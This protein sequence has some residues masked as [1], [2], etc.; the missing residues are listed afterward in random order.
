MLPVNQKL[1]VRGGAAAWLIYVVDDDDNEWR[2][3]AMRMMVKLRWQQ[4][5][6]SSLSLHLGWNFCFPPVFAFCPVFTP[7]CQLLLPPPPLSSSPSIRT[8]VYFLIFSFHPVVCRLGPLVRWPEAG[9]CC[10]SQFLD[11]WTPL[12]DLIRPFRRCRPPQLSSP[13]PENSN[14]LH[15]ISI[16]SSLLPPRLCPRPSPAPT[17]FTWNCK[18]GVYHDLQT[19]SFKTRLNSFFHL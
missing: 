16:F 3:K 5:E 18:K 19:S 17:G 10:S 7:L 6:G 2:R 14:H 12:K 13:T 4:P 11:V 8:Q 15:F 9:G 1:S